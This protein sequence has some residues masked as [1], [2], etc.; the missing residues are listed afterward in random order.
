[1][2][3]QQKI[4]MVVEDEKLLLE[5]I[6]KK[7]SISGYMVVAYSEGKRALQDLLLKKV[8]P[9]IIWLDYYLGDMNGIEFMQGLNTSSIAI[10]VLIVSN[11]ADDHKVKTV[12]GLGAKKYI[13]KAQYRLEEIIS[14]L[15][16]LLKELQ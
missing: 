4:V 2:N 14:E 7:L 13:L 15:Q 8:V 10:P 5:A 16:S 3:T 9:D 12:L 1:M 11:S 6:T